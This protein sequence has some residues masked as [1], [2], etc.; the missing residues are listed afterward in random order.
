MRAVT[1]A[2]IRA[3]VRA[4]I[5]ITALISHHRETFKNAQPPLSLAFCLLYSDNQSTIPAIV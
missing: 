3:L 1:R 2:L 4:L 5:R